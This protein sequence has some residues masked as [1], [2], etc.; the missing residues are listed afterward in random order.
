MGLSNKFSAI[1]GWRRSPIKHFGDDEVGLGTTGMT[2]GFENS[3]RLVIPQ[4]FY[5]G[6]Q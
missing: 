4:V 6:S 5:A 3:V 1:T 2:K